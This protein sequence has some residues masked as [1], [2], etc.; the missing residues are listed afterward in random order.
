M[1]YCFTCTY[2]IIEI[3]TFVARP[4]M[5]GAQSDVPSATGTQVEC[6]EMAFELFIV[7]LYVG[8]IAQRDIYDYTSH[9]YMFV[10]N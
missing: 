10:G 9:V 1:L 3:I 6:G 4:F 5:Y 7:D 2:I 8:H